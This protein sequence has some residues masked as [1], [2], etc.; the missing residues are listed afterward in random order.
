MFVEGPDP[1]GNAQQVTVIDGA[2]AHTL[3]QFI[4][5]KSSS[6]VAAVDDVTTPTIRVDVQATAGAITT[7]RV[8]AFLSDQAVWVDNDSASPITVVGGV[9]GG[10]LK[11]VQPWGA[12]VTAV[13]GLNA[14]Q[15]IIFNP[16]IG[17][18]WVVDAIT[19]SFSGPTAGAP[20]VS[21][22]VG[23]V[24]VW[25]AIMRDAAVSSA[26]GHYTFPNGGMAP[27]GV[28]ST[29]FAVTQTASGAAGIAGV[30]N[31]VTHQIPG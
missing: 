10:V 14:A 4:F 23:G 7:G 29:G 22:L 2:T 26:P 24:T 31:V 3:E 1:L 16:V 11:V 15:S 6:L 20:G 25:Q 17:L 5:P 18:I 21:V 28:S 30:L 27:A 8:V 12:V 9:A 13:S 19:I